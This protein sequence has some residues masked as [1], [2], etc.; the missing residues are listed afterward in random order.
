MAQVIRI[1]RYDQIKVYLF[2]FGLRSVTPQTKKFEHANYD[3]ILKCARDLDLGIVKG[4]VSVDGT[5]VAELDAKDLV[6]NKLFNVVELNTPM[7]SFT[8]PPGTHLF[9]PKSGTFLADSTRLVRF[10]KTV[11][12]RRSYSQLHH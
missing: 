1:A 7:F 10:L 3:K 4:K 9:T 5:L 8:Y 11:T 6:S 12:T 2:N